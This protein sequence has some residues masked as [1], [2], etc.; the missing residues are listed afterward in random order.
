[1]FPSWIFGG[2]K[3]DTSEGPPEPSSSSSSSSSL[4]GK[5][6]VIIGGGLAGLSVAYNLRKLSKDVQIKLVDPKQYSEILWTSY[7][8]PF[9]SEWVGK[10]SIIVLDRYCKEYNVEHIQATVTKLTKESITLDNN[11]NDTT[12]SLSFDVCV[13]ATGA[14]SDWEGGMGRSLPKAK[15]EATPHYRLQQMKDEGQRLLNSKHIIIVGG[16]LIGTELAGEIANE[17]KKKKNKKDN[18]DTPKVTLVHSTSCLCPIMSVDAGNKIQEMLEGLGV[19]VILNEKASIKEEDGGTN[20]DGSD[21]KVVILQN[22]KKELTGDVVIQTIGF[23]SRNGFMK[24]LVVSGEDA[25]DSK[26]F[27]QTDEYFVVRGCGDDGTTNNNNNVFA[28]GDC[29]NSLP[30]AANVYMRT[31]NVLANNIKCT[32]LSSASNK[33][34][35]TAENGN[36]TKSEAADGM[37]KYE[38]PFSVYINTIGDAQGVFYYSSTIWT[39]YL[40][41]WIKNKTMF[42]MSPREFIGLKPEFTLAGGATVDEKAKTTVTT[43]TD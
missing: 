6:V 2:K 17:V 33:T 4:A 42:F 1:M 25:F 31:A 16:G 30:N 19:T 15:D 18:C 12:T 24:D 10:N 7:R 23:G 38:I 41:P 28:F 27:I 9:D 34:T 8:S 29:S 20:G 32:L 22:S 14:T 37:M 36:G 13:V 35:T 3:D 39:Q 40:L 26:G 11:D 21:T 5:V 43:T